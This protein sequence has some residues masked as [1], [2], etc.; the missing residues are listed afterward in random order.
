[1][2]SG[3]TTNLL[4][5]KY[6]VE[7]YG[8]KTSLYKPILDTRSQDVVSRTGLKAPVDAYIE[9][10]DSIIKNINN[11]LNKSNIIFIDECQFMSYN[12]IISFGDLCSKSDSD[13]IVMAYGLLKD[14]NNKL[15]DGSQGWLE[16]SDKYREIK[17]MCQYPSCRRKATCN[18]LNK[19]NDSDSNVVIGGDDIYS[20][21]CRK[22]YNEK[23]KGGE[24]HER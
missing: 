20:C 19:S 10:L 12:D 4:T 14:Y 6:Q 7:Q 3:K 18:Y 17:S 2:N 16:I 23:V 8:I 9:N 15:F 24:N 22:H 13:S 11:D 1:M 21:Y 5:T